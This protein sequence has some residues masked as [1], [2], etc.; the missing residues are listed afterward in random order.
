MED[1]VHG[2]AF[3]GPSGIKSHKHVNPWGA[4]G[5]MVADLLDMIGAIGTVPFTPDLED[6]SIRIAIANNTTPRCQ[7]YLLSEKWISGFSR[8]EISYNGSSQL[9][10]APY[11][12]GLMAA[13]EIFKA[14]RRKDDNFTQCPDSCFYSLLS[15]NA[16]ADMAKFENADDSPE[17][18][19][20]NIE[21]AGAGAVGMAFAAC[22]WSIPNFD[23]NI[24]AIDGD[25]RG[26]DI[27]NLNRYFIAGKNDLNAEKAEL[28]ARK[29]SRTGFSVIPT[30]SLIEDTQTHQIDNK[31]G[32]CALDNNNSRIAYMERYLPRMLMGSTLELCAKISL[33]GPPGEGACL[34]CYLEPE[35]LFAEADALFEFKNASKEEKIEICERIGVTVEEAL[36]AIEATQCSTVKDE[37]IAE[38]TETQP[39]TEQWSVSFVS[40]FCGVLLATVL[41]RE[42]IGAPISGNR[43]LFQ[44]VNPIADVNDVE[45]FPRRDK[46]Q[47]CAQENTG[48]RV[49]NARYQE[50]TT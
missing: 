19:T 36:S 18:S 33:A 34:A 49:W 4:G 3:D 29:L 50:F 24:H 15:F 21:L 9:P 11:C 43:I 37:I 16:S 12:A 39:S 42:C 23:V 13:A 2:I 25:P 48:L 28:L 31:I 47:H 10:F 38:V 40:G 41:Y 17:N 44:F 1:V 8:R 26:I 45:A 32:V 46:C 30:H 20:A 22:L 14:I 35:P 27:T 5:S 7:L 6:D